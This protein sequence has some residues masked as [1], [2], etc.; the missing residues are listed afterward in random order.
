MSDWH[1]QE[2]F[3]RLLLGVKIENSGSELTVL[4]EL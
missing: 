3:I 4:L 1:V 2:I